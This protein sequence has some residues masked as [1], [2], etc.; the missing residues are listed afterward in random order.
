[1]TDAPGQVLGLPNGTPNPA[2]SPSSTPF[3]ANPA[4]AE[5]APPN[6]AAT[7]TPDLT[8]PSQPF[9]SPAPQP[10]AAAPSAVQT[11]GP[12]KALPVAPQEIITRLQIF[13]DQRH[14]G[15]GKIDGRWG[16]FTAKALIRYQVALGQ[17]PT[18]QIDVAMQQEL[19]KIFPI[20]TTYTLAAEDLRQVNHE[21]P[22]KPSE[23]AHAKALVYRSLA[24][25]LGER[26]HSDEEFIAKLNRG[27]NLEKLKPGDLVRVPN[28]Q[29]FEI[30]TLKEV[31]SVPLKPQLA[32]RILKVDTRYRMLDVIDGNRLVCSFPITP[33]SKRLPAP[34]GTWKI[35]GIATLPWFRWDE[36]M[37][38]HGQRSDDY[39][40]LPP[41]PRNP[42]GVVW[43]GLSKRGIGIHGTNSPGTIGRSGSH[44]C[45]RL[46]N[47]DAARIINEVTG[48]MTVQ[49]F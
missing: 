38:E 2:N 43:I 25:F 49:I 11:G 15:P 12:P 39:Y 37:L 17:K 5:P 27:V 29:P 13:L 33:G 22:Y 44:G 41:G 14:F 48:G 46:A 4:L 20:Y 34:I 8:Y 32:G 7:P 42:V 3:V 10:S 45:I 6:A 21:L 26:F 16:E 19:E 31:A 28:V 47:W 1:A 23:E 18:G 35:V 36:A 24:E 30:E 40:N 9:A